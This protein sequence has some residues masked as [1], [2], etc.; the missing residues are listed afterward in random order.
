MK[1]ATEAAYATLVLRL[2]LDDTVP[3]AALNDLD[4][5]T[6]LRVTQRSGTLVRAAARLAALGVTAPTFVAAAV[7]QERQRV[8]EAFEL[9]HHVTAACAARGIA[10]LFPKLLQ[11]YP[12][13]GDDLD[14]LVVT[15]SAR[16]DA[17]ILHGCR[18]VRRGSR[19][20]GWIAGSASYRV[21]G[22]FTPLDIQHGRLGIVGEDTT[23]PAILWAGRRV[24][25][26]AGRDVIT[27][28]PEHVL[29]LHGMQ[30][31]YGRLAIDLADV[32]AVMTSIRRDRLDWSLIL[33]TATRLGVRPGLEAF[34]GYVEQI[35]GRV[36][37]RSLLPEA[38]RARLR[39]DGWGVPAF[40]A[41]SYRYPVLRVNVALYRQRLAAALAAR[42]WAVALRLF[43]VPVIVLDRALRRPF[44]TPTSPPG[45][46]I[47]AW[48]SAPQP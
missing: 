21:E 40:G 45:A 47:G 8:A 15:P 6:L 11:H 1:R 3:R 36:F 42:H 44:R 17:A 9:V 32:A 26:I 43:L 25:Q 48:A 2:L 7:E 33:E 46:S 18:A 4:W 12:D 20:A 23:F 41:G 39:L 35:H 31:L 24:T 28:S 22:C 38:V 30:R 29:V 5:A 37:G 34:L 27:A 16:V 14:L 10:A 19:L 13:L